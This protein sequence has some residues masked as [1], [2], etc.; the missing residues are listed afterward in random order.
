MFGI[1]PAETQ[2][3]RLVTIHGLKTRIYQYQAFGVYWQMVTS[4]SVGGGF[5]ADDM[6][7][8]KTL[9]FLAYII[10]DN[11]PFFGGT[12]TTLGMTETEDI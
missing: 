12:S 2:A 6:G 7:L 3:D 5:V 11:S 1:N 4:R 8:G 10:V 9:S